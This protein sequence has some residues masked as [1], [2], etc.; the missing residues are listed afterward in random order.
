MAHLFKRDRSPY[1]WIQYRPSTSTKRRSESTGYRHSHIVQ[2][3]LARE[4]EARRTLA[5]RQSVGIIS[6]ERWHVWVPSFIASR[7]ADNPNS[8]TRYAAAWRV[9]RMWLDELEI[10]LPRQLT[11]QHCE[12]YTAW[13]LKPDPENSRFR[14]GHNTIVLEMKFM[15]L[16]M[17]QAVR[18]GYAQGNPCREL[19]L[20]RDPRKIFPQ[21]NDDQIRFIV[22]A[23][24]REP[25]AKRAFLW[26]SFIIAWHHGVRLV[27]THLNPLTDIALLARP[28]ARSKAKTPAAVSRCGTIT[29]HQKGG[30][31][32][33]KPLHPQLYDFFS[34]LQKNKKPETFPMPK[35]F[36]KEWFLF[37]RRAGIKAVLPAACFHSFRVTAQNRLRRASIPREIRKAYLSH[38]GFD[39][40]HDR[41]TRIEDSG[42]DIGLDE[43]LVCHAPLNKIWD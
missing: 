10:N 20:K 8:L 19:R 18:L 15:A 25:E 35:S 14:A 13:R 2:T 1:W 12:D 3:R 42:D 16:V 21:Y 33:A 43:M 27:E 40:V 26:P 28:K 9:L 30:K 7:Y 11:Y 5:E 4:L 6:R 31:I 32:R 34:T 37:L 41:Y 22:S 38:E 29:F 23:I 36:A 24:R 39:D 17:Q